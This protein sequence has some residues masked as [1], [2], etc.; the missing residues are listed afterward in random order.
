MPKTIIQKIVFRNT[1]AKDLYDL[2][3]NSKKHSISTGARATIST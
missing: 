2:Y 3:M 1:T